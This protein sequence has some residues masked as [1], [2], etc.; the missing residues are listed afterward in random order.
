M[1]PIGTKK[2]MKQSMLFTIICANE[3]YINNMNFK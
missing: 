1:V 3:L 2:M